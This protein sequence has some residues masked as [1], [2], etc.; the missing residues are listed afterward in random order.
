MIFF[1][2]TVHTEGPRNSTFFLLFFFKPGA[3][4]ALS[5]FW[6]SGRMIWNLFCTSLSAIRDSISVTEMAKIYRLVRTTHLPYPSCFPSLVE[7][8]FQSLPVDNVNAEWSAWRGGESVCNSLISLFPSCQGYEC[9]IWLTLMLSVF[10]FLG[11]VNFRG[12]IWRKGW[13]GNYIGRNLGFETCLRT[14]IP[15]HLNWLIK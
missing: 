6:S 2:I 10:I 12:D 8:S 7:D 13:F 3:E 4:F 14:S 15:L 11:G 1:F 9:V 5:A